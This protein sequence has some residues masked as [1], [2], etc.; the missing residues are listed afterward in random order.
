[1]KSLKPLLLLLAFSIVLSSGMKC[2]KDNI[3]TPEPTLPAETQTGAETFGCLVDGKV[4]VPKGNF[5]IPGLSTV[6]Q[7]NILNLSS[8][9]ISESI[10][11]GINNMNSVGEYSVIGTNRAGYSNKA[12]QNLDATDGKVTILK[13]DKTNK[14]LSGRFYFIGKDAASGKTINITDGRFDVKYTD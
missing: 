11:I 8:T 2:K 3:V 10:G 4:F 9:R 1:M 6:I 14:I 7:F 5:T 12:G 13:Y